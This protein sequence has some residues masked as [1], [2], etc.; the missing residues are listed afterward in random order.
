MDINHHSKHVVVAMSGGVDSSV[1]A[2]LLLEQGYRVTGLMLH[3]WCECEDDN[4]CCTPEAIQ[5][6]R[7]VASQLGFPFYAV[8]A[9]EQFRQ[10]VVKQFLEDY[11]N[12]LTPNPCYVCNQQFRWNFLLKWALSMGADALASGHYAQVR[13]NETDVFE[14]LRGVDDSKDQSYMLSGLNQDMLS[15]MILPLGTW[16]KTDIRQKAREL[17]LSVA[18]KE[19]SQD[20]CFLGNQDY[21]D[22]LKQH[23]PEAVKPGEIVNHQGEVLGKH[24]GL[25][26]Y[27]IGQRKGLGVTGASPLY[28]LNKQ[29]AAN[30]LVI[31]GEE[32]LGRTELTADHFNWITG[33]PIFAPSLL[34]VKIRY[35]ADFKEGLV[36]PVG[37]DK[38]RIVFNEPLRDIT[39]GQIAAVYNNDIVLG[40]GIIRT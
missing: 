32:E 26:F 13:K 10:T 29:V 6:A 33:E 20:L 12:G 17:N 23:A 28:V 40:S 30:R 14:L 37:K 21:R 11:V 34:Q 19:D 31:G 8:D 35:R 2:A 27:T 25:A 22:F 7:Q 39:P 36:A 38:V 15:H 3:L 24:D 4:K 18:E 5:Q 1:A 16:N 9:G